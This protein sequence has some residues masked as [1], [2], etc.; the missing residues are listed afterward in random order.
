MHLTPNPPKLDLGDCSVC[1]TPGDQ[2]SNSPDGV[3]AGSIRIFKGI[4]HDRSGTT[5]DENG[6]EFFLAA[7]PRRPLRRTLRVLCVFAVQSIY[8]RKETPQIDKPT[9]PRREQDVARTLVR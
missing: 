1:A 3:G 7:K 5:E 2:P 6:R 4:A 9:V 8:F